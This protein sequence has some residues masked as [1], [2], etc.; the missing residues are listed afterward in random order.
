MVTP[1]ATTPQRHVLEIVP[2]ARQLAVTVR[3][4]VCAAV[5]TIRDNKSPDTQQHTARDTHVDDTLRG[6]VAAAGAA[7][8]R[9][10]VPE[11]AVEIPRPRG[12]LQASTGA[13]R[14]GIYT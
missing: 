6:S 14:M 1:Q 8:V 12:R 4:A 3:P 9:A 5:A 7:P 13:F 2:G 10:G 11:A